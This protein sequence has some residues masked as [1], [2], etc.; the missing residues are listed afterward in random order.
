[1]ATRPAP[2][3]APAAPATVQ[4]PKATIP[5][6]FELDLSEPVTIS[7]S[8]RIVAYGTGGIGK[9]T[10]AA[11]MPAPVFFDIERSTKK[12]QVRKDM[13]LYRDASWPMLRSKVAG[14]AASPPAGARSLV[15]DTV[16][17]AEQL[18][19]DHVV[20]TRRTDKGKRVDSVEGFGWQKGWQY[21]YDE[22]VAL[23][24]DLDRVADSGFNVCLIAHD[25]STVFPNPAGE[26]YPRWEPLLH[27][28]DK[29]GRYNVR[30]LL[31]NWCEHLVYFGYDVHVEEGKAQGSSTRS[32]YT[33]ELPTHMAKSRTAQI[34]EPFTIE[35]PG[36]VW[37]ALGIV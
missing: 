19:V 23:L 15:I 27:A 26:D 13:D 29:R 28:G 4:S 9:S 8:D 37:Q 24:A 21:V 25:V 36:A 12:L 5:E 18:A 1:M 35:N 6:P 16:T 31:K 3:P 30:A 17:S 33:I 32:V 10:A 2:P 22:F 14:F 34:A 7:G 20:A 11:W